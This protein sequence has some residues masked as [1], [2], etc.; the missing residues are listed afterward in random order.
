M[1]DPI[2]PTDDEAAPVDPFEAELVAYLDGELDA[3]AARRVEARLASD[4]KARARA[5][6]LKKTFDLLDYLPK[7]EP[8]PTFTS[9]TLDK[10]PAIQPQPVQPAGSQPV[11]LSQAS[12]PRT[13]S[14]TTSQR[15]GV[16]VLPARPEPRWRRAVWASG[17]LLAVGGFAT[18]GYLGASALRGNNATPHRQNREPQD[19]TPADEQLIERLPLYTAV[20]DFAFVQELARPEYFGDEPAVSYEPKGPALPSE[21]L[22]GAAFAAMEKAFK[23]LPVERQQAIRRLDHQLRAE[24]PPA[25]DRM[26]RV[27]EA[28]TIWLNRLPDQDHAEVLAAATSTAR[29]EAIHHIRERQWVESLP[30]RLRS[31]F[32]GMT[33]ANRAKRIEEL[34]REE[35]NRKKDWNHVRKLPD[36]I[37]ETSKIAWPFNDET[38]RN[39]VIAFAH[40][41]FRLDGACRLTQSDH[42]GYISELQAARQSGGSSWELYGQRVYDLTRKHEH[43]LLPAPPGS[44]HHYTNIQSL[45]LEYKTYLDR[46]L[47]IKSRK[48]LT[49]LAGK[50]PEF[51]LEVLKQVHRHAKGSAPPA[52]PLGPA[53]VIEFEPAVR[54]TVADSLL[55]KLSPAEEKTLAGLEGK[56]PDYPRELIRLARVHDVSIP[57]V[58]LPGSPKKWDELYGPGA[59]KQ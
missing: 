9:R 37:P 1:A 29:L 51:P 38:K 42:D 48:E 14:S 41:A 16:A 13:S 59:S 31:Q 52:T 44:S 39:E 17:L 53:R 26:T 57:G 55:K 22:S 34:R 6:S 58:M 21:K 27:L 24:S 45:P 15:N 8:S 18:A 46:H 33:P 40:A 35:A 30:P 43:V 2:M 28:Y 10:L 36:T 47:D 5:A 25:R 56:W 20:D 54:K 4:A 12:V 32:Q 49:V 19:L 23:S 50:W 11:R 7:P 3:A